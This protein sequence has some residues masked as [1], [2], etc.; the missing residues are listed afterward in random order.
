MVPGNITM[1]TGGIGSK[2]DSS[3]IST[4][5][6]IKGLSESAEESGSLV[7]L[8]P[9]GWV[10]QRDEDARTSLAA[11]WVSSGDED[12]GGCMLGFLDL[13]GGCDASGRGRDGAPCFFRNNIRMRG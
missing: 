9:T 4:H 2:Q 6:S 12:A 8:S 10:N 3:E 1:H 5:C 13:D 7:V 11:G